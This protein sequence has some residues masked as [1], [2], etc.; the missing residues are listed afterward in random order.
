MKTSVD[1]VREIRDKIYEETKN[2][3]RE[4]EDEYLRQAVRDGLN[5]LEKI[6]NK[7]EVKQTVAAS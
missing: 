3:T 2:M 4:Q 7:R 5:R 6:K 1:E